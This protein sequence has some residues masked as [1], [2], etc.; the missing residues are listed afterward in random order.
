MSLPVGLYGAGAPGRA[1]LALLGGRAAQTAPISMLG[2]PDAVIRLDRG[3]GPWPPRDQRYRGTCVPH[4][5]VAAMELFWRRE[6]RTVDLSPDYLY[7]QMRTA[8]DPALLADYAQTVPGY[9]VGAT[10]LDQARRVFKD[11]G[12]CPLEARPPSGSL[13]LTSLGGPAATQAQNEAAEAWKHDDFVHARFPDPLAPTP[14]S[15]PGEEG[16]TS[17]AVAIH[18]LLQRGS[19]VA[20]GLP[21]FRL[22]GG[23]DNWTTAYARAHGTVAYPGAA[24]AARPEATLQPVQTL[25]HAVCLVGYAPDPEAPG[26]GWFLFRNSWG[27]DFRTRPAPP[28]DDQPG[29]G[30]GRLSAAAVDRFVWELLAPVRASGT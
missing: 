27:L 12:C 17:V 19:P 28:G 16:F 9:A 14:I 15:I 24:L 21:V 3:I 7:V 30:Q 20:V 22:G 6:G 25:G 18:R 13:P 23:W 2:L 29:P 5:A 8:L 4:A 26:G 11:I 1:T 10:V